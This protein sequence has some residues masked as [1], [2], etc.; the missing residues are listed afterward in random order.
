MLINYFT[1]SKYVVATQQFLPQVNFL[2]SNPTEYAHVSHALLCFD[3]VLDSFTA[4]LHS[5]SG[6]EMRATS[7]SARCVCQWCLKQW[8]YSP[9]RSRKPTNNFHW[10][11]ANLYIVQQITKGWCQ[12][13]G[14][15]SY[16]HHWQSNCHQTS[17]VTV[18][19]WSHHKT[20]S[21]QLLLS[22]MRPPFRERPWGKVDVHWTTEVVPGASCNI[23]GPTA[24]AQRSLQ[25]QLRLVTFHG[26]STGRPGDFVL[27]LIRARP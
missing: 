8:Q 17:C 13:I 23:H 3:A 12:L 18:S 9:V 5:P 7:G 4:S 24:F 11:N 6:R 22:V 16:I 21:R 15:V 19:I 2:Y 25:G 20:T 1:K 14:H 10:G 26:S 27:Q